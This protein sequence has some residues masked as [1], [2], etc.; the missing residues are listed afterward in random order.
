M[1]KKCDKVLSRKAYLANMF[2]LLK[3]SV[4]PPRLL[5]CIL[6]FFF[7]LSL[8]SNCFSGTFPIDSLIEKKGFFYE[9][10]TG[11]KFSGNV[12]SYYKNSQIKHTGL[13][14]FGRLEGEWRHYEEN[15][16]LWLIENYQAGQKQGEWLR[17]HISGLKWKFGQYSQNQKIGIWKF[18]SIDGDLIEKGEFLNDKKMEFGKNT[19]SLVK[20]GFKNLF[21]TI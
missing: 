19:M 18:Y 17:Y 11:K 15:G 4:V 3:K 21:K 10:E 9:E 8:Y 12:I 14:R 13:L 5:R 16:R 7:V 6:Y 1:Y 20:S 2:F